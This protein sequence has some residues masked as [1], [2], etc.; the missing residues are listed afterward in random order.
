MILLFQP[1]TLDDITVDPVEDDIEIVDEG[2]TS[3]A[4]AVSLCESFYVHNS[5]HF[6][7]IKSAYTL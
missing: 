3:D 5:T 6:L 4:F 7:I 1:Q 2:S